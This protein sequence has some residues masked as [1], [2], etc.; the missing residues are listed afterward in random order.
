MSDKKRFNA[1]ERLEEYAKEHGT[2]DK[3]KNSYVITEKHAQFDFKL[4]EGFFEL[5]IASTPNGIVVYSGFNKKKLDEFVSDYSI[6]EEEL[7]D[8]FQPI[9]DEADNV[10]VA[11]SKRLGGKLND[12][13]LSILKKFDTGLIKKLLESL[14]KN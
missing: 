2:Y 3:E 9:R 11:F 12:E 14:D 8:M 5:N 6:T 13:I 7:D 4:P 1:E 10:V